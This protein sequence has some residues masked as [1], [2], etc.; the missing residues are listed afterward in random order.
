VIADVVSY[1]DAI[2]RAIGDELAADDDVFL[3]G[4]DIAAAGGVFKLT[5]G[6]LDRFG[7]RRVLDTPISEQAIV[8]CAIGAATQG[9]RPIAEIMFAD[10]S[11]VAFDQIANEL[12]KYRYMS[13]GQVTLPV[14]LRLVNGAGGGFGA[15]HSQPVENWFLNVAGL[16]I[17][18]PATP[19]DAYA[20]LREAVRDPNP[21]L[22]FEHKR[23]LT[24][25]GPLVEPRSAAGFGRAH[26]VRRGGDVTVVATQLMRHRA[27]EAAER[28]A[29]EGIELEVIDPRTLMP[30]DHETIGQSVD[31]TNRLVVVQEC[32]VP[33]SW[34][35][36]VV[37]EVARERFESLD[38]PPVIVA[39]DHT[40]VPYADA[41]EAAWMPSVDRI[42]A[43]VREAVAY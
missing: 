10:F 12:A 16:K 28:L 1:R 23:L 21:V 3:I 38:A 18:V 33:G 8:G 15:Q 39:A 34:G 5:D 24:V 6:L 14:T 37:A 26:V 35:A 22:V 42:V 7:P 27:L 30:L 2:N 20:L 40:P 31:H 43:S 17:A 13:G 32:S 4:E 41:L 19:A 36:T 9:L 29:P 25:K 11:G